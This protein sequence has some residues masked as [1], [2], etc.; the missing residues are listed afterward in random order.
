[1]AQRITIL[2]APSGYGKTTAMSELADKLGQE[3]HGVVWLNVDSTLSERTTFWNH[4]IYTLTGG[5]AFIS[6]LTSDMSAMMSRHWPISYL[7]FK[8]VSD[9]SGLYVS[10]TWRD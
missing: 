10:T 4:V 8:T 3:G 7:A 6:A 1:M 9:M 5:G 2:H